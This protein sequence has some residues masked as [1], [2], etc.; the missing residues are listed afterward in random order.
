MK[1]ITLLLLVIL[2]VATFCYAQSPRNP[3]D[4]NDGDPDGWLSSTIGRPGNPRIE[5]FA[6]SHTTSFTNLNATGLSVTGNPSY[7]ALTN[8]DNVLYYIWIDEAGDLIM[9]SHETMYLQS[10]NFPGGS[11]KQIKEWV[12][13]VGKVGDQS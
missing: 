2:L 3:D 1:K 9:A 10:P 6:S 7:I 8:V 5:G 12:T 13:G 4:L 11:W